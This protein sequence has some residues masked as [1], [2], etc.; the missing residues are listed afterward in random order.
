MLGEAAVN[1]KAG[2]VP[3]VIAIVAVDVHPALLPVTVYVVLVVGVM[4][5]VFVVTLPALALHV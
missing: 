4:A 5:T 1:V 3:T 2:G